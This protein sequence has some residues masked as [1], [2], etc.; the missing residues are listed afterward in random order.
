MRDIADQGFR[1]FRRFGLPLFI[2]SHLLVA[3]IKIFIENV[4]ADK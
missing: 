4:R 1:P 3:E 2:L